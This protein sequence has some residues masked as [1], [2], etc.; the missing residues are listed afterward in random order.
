MTQVVLCRYAAYLA[1]RLA[2]SSIRQY[3]NIIRL[4]HLE[5]GF[6]NPL[7]NN[8]VLT[9]ILKGIARLKGTSVSR[10]LPITPV[11]LLGIRDQLNFSKP[12]DI[13]FWAICLL[14]FFG[15]LRKSNV[16]PL[17]AKK[18]DPSHHVRRRDFVPFS[19][20]L[21]LEIRWSKTIQTKEKVLVIPLPILPRHPLCPVKAILS[22]F[23]V[24][25]GLPEGPAFPSS[26]LNPF[27]PV[28]AMQ[29]TTRL[30]RL[31]SPLVPDIG[32]YSTHSFRRGGASWA[33][34]CGIPSDLIKL[35]GDWKSDA[36]R[37]YLHPSMPLR[38]ETARCFASYLP[39]H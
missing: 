21:G 5:G 19:W 9:S 15:L 14:L 3:L 31:L 37:K 33:L 28:T 8:W 6:P 29:F 30:A 12:V 25:P 10:K 24:M 22:A 32:V 38:L 36:Y 2:V 39:T 13:V 20:G 1:R 4:L 18:F 16:L 17:S 35:L 7:S 23:M 26:P 11:L 34:Q 27:Q